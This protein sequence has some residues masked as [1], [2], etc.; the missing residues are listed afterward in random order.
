VRKN[1]ERFPASVAK[2]LR[3]DADGSPIG[4][5]L[6]SKDITEQKRLEAQ[7]QRT[8][9]ELEQQA[10]RVQEANRMKSEFLANMSHE[11]RTPL[12]GIIGF[13]E[14]MYDG[15]VGA[16][17]AQH[18]EYLALI[19]KS[20]RHLLQLVNDVLDL[21]KVESGKFEF[22]PEPVDLPRL[23]G[24]VTGVQQSVAAQTHVRVDV[25]IADLGQVVVDPAKLKQVIYNY[26]SNAIKFSRDGGRVRIRVTGEGSDLFRIEV[27]DT[28]I[29]IKPED[30]DR[31]FVEFQQLDASA[32]KKH[33]GT[34]LG[35]ALTKRIVEAQGGQVGV[36]SELG[37]GSTFF[38]V[39]PRVTYPSPGTVPLPPE[40]TVSTHA[41]SPTIL[42]VEDGARDGS[43]L[44]RELSGAGYNVRS[45][46]TGSEASEIARTE[47]VDLVTLDLLH[48]D[49]SG[50]DV[51]DHIRAEGRN[52]DVPV[53]VV[54]QTSDPIGTG[55]VGM[56][57]CLTKPAAA[58]EME[59]ALARVGAS[60]TAGST[61]LVVDDDE[62][63][64]RYAEHALGQLGY[65]TI[66]CADGASALAAAAAAPPDAVVLDLLMP[67]IDG[68]AFLERFRATPAGAT[69]PVLVWTGK[70]LTRA[71]RQQLH[72]SA[73]AIVSKA[74]GEPR[75]LLEELR[76]YVREPTDLPRSN[77]PTRAKRTRAA[78]PRKE[79]S[80]GR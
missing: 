63:N 55:S 26:L 34:G 51:L 14:L 62:V 65:Q 37:K 21:A 47:R 48:P 12:N 61:I 33:Q 46:V 42:V 2:T 79:Q 27:E 40:P 43:W 72:A 4:Y 41:G 74:T 28:G 45:A 25:E 44:A 67:G 24:E 3:R 38:A 15:K 7:I 22:V 54:S 39:L 53:V 80:N 30:I 49:M 23:L 76:R 66:C 52:R 64:L 5:V 57:E 59:A 11:L 32:A 20:S 16:L 9:E 1:G 56:A 29:G 58:A 18:Q 50:C 35:L 17:A 77:G 60:P 68:F 70:D 36:R 75:A 69:V 6:I 78:A 10:R 13:S 73:Q 31:L 8:N 71:E 19:L